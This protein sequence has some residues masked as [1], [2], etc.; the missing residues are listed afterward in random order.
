MVSVARS[1]PRAVLPPAPRITVD[2]FDRIFETVKNWGRWGPD[3][4]LGTLNYLT[5]ER[6]AAATRLVQSGRTVSLGLPINRVA[7]PDN[8]H[9]AVHYMSELHSPDGIGPVRFSKDF[10]GVEMHG[11]SHS[12]LDALC[13]TSYRGLLYNGRPASLVT[14]SGGEVLGIDRYERGIV[15]RGVLL[16]IARLRGVDWLEPGEAVTPAELEAAEDQAGARLGE[17]DILV[18]RTGHDLR[19]RMVI[20]WDSSPSGEGKA[21]VSLD[22]VVWMHERHIAAFLPDGDGETVPGPVEGLD[23]PVHAMQIVAMGMAAA[24]ALD[25]EA[26]AAA[27]RDEGRSEFLVVVAPLKLPGGTGSLVNPIAVF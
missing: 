7:G 18:L 9:P 24:D 21:G 19:R 25:L 22:A 5:P 17:G 2:D 3:D 6:S 20:G 8:P 15:G 16:D 13:H 26:L 27:C 14:S 23:G 1:G 12:H 11:N 4:E 10:L